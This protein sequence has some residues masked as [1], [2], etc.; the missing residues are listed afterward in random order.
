[1]KKNQ[2]LGLLVLSVACIANFAPNYA[3]YQLSPLA[4]DLMTA[5]NISTAQYSSIFTAVLIPAIILSII[6]GI[7][8]DRFGLKRVIGIGLC[9]TA[10]GTCQKVFANEYLVLIFCMFLTGTGATLLNANGAKLIGSYFSKEKSVTM[11]SVFLGSATLAMAI[12]MGTTNLLFGSLK[13][14]FVFSAVLSLLGMV[15]W[16]AF[17]REPQKDRTTDI[18]I[19]ENNP[20]ILEGLK[21]VLRNKYIWLTG[22]CLIGAVGSATAMNALLPTAL[23]QRG[24]EEVEAGFIASFMPIGN[25]I[26]CLVIPLIAY[27]FGKNKPV[28]I[29]CA[30][31]G[32]LGAAFAWMAPEGLLLVLALFLTGATLSGI[33]PLVMPIPIQMK[34]IGV[35]YGGT[36]GGVVSTIEMVGVVIVP[37][38]IIAVLA[39]NNMTFYYLLCGVCALAALITIL[40]LPDFG[41]KTYK[42]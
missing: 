20:G 14:A 18:K 25:L 8:A 4:S 40:F 30:V 6:A 1:M 2:K 19:E 29:F 28:L 13:S 23:V 15:L 24:V 32:A 34:E 37:A 26:G 22:I 41:R 9:I 33:V 10:F 21:I 27:R 39:G 42:H 11:M 3:Q 31:I 35:T 12:G 17:V 38:Y 16:L 7:L 5:F 36:A